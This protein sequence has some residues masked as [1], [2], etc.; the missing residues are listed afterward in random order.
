MMGA[1]KHR[2]PAERAICPVCGR[3]TA[4]MFN[5][6]M[7]LGR[8]VGTYLLHPHNLEPGVRCKG[9]I[10]GKEDLVPRAPVGEQSSESS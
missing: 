4:A 2:S 8:M 10:A 9:W 6:D 1:R 7:T 5:A 3:N